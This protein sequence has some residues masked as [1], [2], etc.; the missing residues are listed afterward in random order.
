MKIKTS[1]LTGPALDWAV[2][3]CKG[4]I[5]GDI[6]TPQFFKKWCKQIRTPALY[7]STDWS[8][9]GPL[10]EREGISLMRYEVPVSM[11][12]V[13]Y[14]WRAEVT[15]SYYP[16]KHSGPTPLIAAMRCLVASKL[17]EE[18]DV[19]DEPINN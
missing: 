3:K 10:I 6:A 2:A 9:G 7:P 15:H 12:M 1:K 8:Q 14:E 5:K 18:V 17:G 13:G 16:H 4:W 11:F 19:P